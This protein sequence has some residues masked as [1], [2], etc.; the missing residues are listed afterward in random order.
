MTRN[1]QKKG[2]TMENEKQEIET[3]TID[4]KQIV[5]ADLSPMGKRSFNRFMELNGILENLNEQVQ[6]ARL[7]ARGYADALANDKQEDEDDA[8]RASETDH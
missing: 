3:I 1:N 7:L 6:E 8:D 2:K 4:D 5:V